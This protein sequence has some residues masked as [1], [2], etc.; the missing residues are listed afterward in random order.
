MPEK[1]IFL[2]NIHL[3]VAFIFEIVYFFEDG[4]WNCVA[5]TRLRMRSIGTKKPS[6]AS[7]IEVDNKVLMETRS[8]AGMHDCTIKLRVNPKKQRDKVCIACG[9]SF[10]GDRPIAALK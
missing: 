8:Q 9:A 1:T 10:G 6:G 5:N 3:V 7:S 2:S 4:D